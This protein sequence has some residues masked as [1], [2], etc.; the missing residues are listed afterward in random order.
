M[1]GAPT[2]RR[3]RNKEEKLARIEEAARALF[4]DKGYEATTTREI[5]DRADIGTGTLFLYFPEKRDLLFMVMRSGLDRAMDEAFATLPEGALVDSFAHVLGRLYAYYE[6]DPRLGREF[7]REWMFVTGDR[8][9]DVGRWGM[10]SLA[11]FAGLVEAAQ[12]RGEATR[13]VFSMHAAYQLFGIYYLGLVS[14]LSGMAPSTEARDMV[15]HSS[16]ELLVRG[17]RPGHGENQ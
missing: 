1:T 9:V 16:I 14:W 12:A 17:L 3:E 11:R 8:Q 13:E 5:A 4:Q 2:G 10:S 6:A 15:V 7:V